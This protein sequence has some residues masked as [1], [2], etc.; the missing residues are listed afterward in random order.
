MS[1]FV[2]KESGSVVMSVIEPYSVDDSD[3]N[4]CKRPGCYTVAFT[5]GPLALVVFKGPGLPQPGL[6]GKLV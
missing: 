3:P 2:R 5:F 4:I 1:L 6:E